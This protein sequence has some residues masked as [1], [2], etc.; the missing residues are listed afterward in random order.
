MIELLK[1]IIQKV[2]DFQLKH[3]ENSDIQFC[4]KAGPTDFVSEVDIQSQEMIVSEIEDLFP[5]AGILGE[6]NCQKNVTDSEYL[7]VIDPLDGTSNYRSKLD[8]WAISVGLLKN[9]SVFEGIVAFPKQGVIKASNEC[10][11]FTDKKAI[12][13][14][15]LYLFGTDRI[16]ELQ[17][18]TFKNLKKRVL[19]ATVPTIYYCLK[20]A[21]QNR[22]G[23]DFALLGTSK[24]WDIA[25]IAA[26]L[27]N[28]GGSLITLDGQELLTSE[29]LSLYTNS[30]G[31]FTKA[32][33]V[34]A[35][36]YP[37]VATLIQEFLNSKQKTATR[38]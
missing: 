24:L 36:V 2:S 7:F 31:T 28:A 9:G 11:S 27:K 32:N 5:K 19:G 30:D 29:I 1:P 23:L 18:F 35:S 22:P 17:T 16:F 3:Y 10:L 26:C 33:P 4:T 8:N 34:I 20:E 38:N 21:F 37:E 12:P 14:E 25:G 13:S 6:E 15:Q